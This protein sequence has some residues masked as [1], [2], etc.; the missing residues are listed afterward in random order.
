MVAH[1]TGGRVVSGPPDRGFAGVS[2]DSR[3]VSV[4]A[5]FV[6]LR[7]ARYDGH[8]FLADVAARG[9]AGLLVAEAVAPVPGVSVIAVDDTLEALQRLGHEV[10][11][12]SGVRLVAITGSTGKTTAKEVTAELLA[13][14]YRV[15]RNSGN[16]NNHVGLPLSLTGLAAGF[17]VAV[18]ELGMNHAGEIRALVDLAEPDVRV[19]TNVG[20]AHI[21]FFGS[22]DAIADAKAEILEAASRDALLVANADDALVMNR[23]ERW[24][25]RLLTFGER[26]G[27]DIRAARVADQGFDGTTADLDTPAGPLTVSVPLP[28]RPQLSNA[29]AA[30]AVATEFGVDLSAIQRRLAGLRPVARRGAVTR[31]ANGARVVDDSYNAS[32]A[33]VQAM[34]A[35]LAATATTG[36]RLAVLGEMLELGDAARRLHEACG[37]A[38]AAAGVSDLVVVGGPAVEGLV[39]GALAGGLTRDHVSRFADSAAAVDRVVSLL[40]ADDVLLVKGSRG[41]RTDLIVDQVVAVVGAAA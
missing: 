37:R 16:L 23:V 3:T 25:G 21:G 26:R 34:L 38:A 40:G 8:S 30:V 13:D 20:D 11:R 1:A 6:A 17:D 28:G 33:A 19:W 32:P 41:T 14:R 39:D 5:L 35:T 2:I 12:Q 18:V 4:D 29:L 9:A 15:F 31:L 22:R 10:R 7:G 36:R 24:R 27:A